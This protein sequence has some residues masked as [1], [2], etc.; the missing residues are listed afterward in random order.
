[1][2]AMKPTLTERMR[3]LR[4]LVRAALRIQTGDI[5]SPEG[6]TAYALQLLT[7]AREAT[8]GRGMDRERAVLRA[9]AHLELEEA[10][11]KGVVH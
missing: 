3:V 8:G 11:P 1:M 5:P 2:S 4:D 10:R 7:E 6:V 9:M